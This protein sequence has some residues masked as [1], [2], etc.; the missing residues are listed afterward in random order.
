M[1]LII[2]GLLVLASC[3]QIFSQKVVTTYY[4]PY[5]FLSTK[6]YSE[7]YRVARIDTLNYKFNG[8]VKDYYKNGKLQMIGTYK[9]NVK[10]GEFLFYYPSG[11]LKTRGFYKDNLRW[12]IWTNYYENGKIKEVLVFNDSFLSVLEYYDKNGNPKVLKGTGDWETQYFNDFGMS[13]ETITGSFKDSLRHGTWTYYSKSLLN[14]PDTSFSPPRTEIYENGKFITGK[15]PRNDGTVQNMSFSTIH[16]LPETK[17]FERTERWES[18]IYASRDE[19]PFLKFLPKVD[20]SYF[21]V[22]KL[23]AFPG[24]IDSLTSQI[25]RQ[26]KLKK[27]YIKTQSLLLCMF[28]IIINEK[29][30][31]EIEEDQ[32]KSMLKLY[33]DKTLFY[34]RVLKALKNLPMWSPAVLHQKYVK[35]HFNITISMEKG[36]LRIN[37]SSINQVILDPNLKLISSATLIKYRI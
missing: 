25:S 19:Y 7:Y 36:L 35:S 11:N 1:R 29:G 3:S 37:L 13:N 17:K 14:E 8:I 5:W 30:I 34:Q 32:N 4:N 20:S 15:Y 26:L 2:S 28:K 9:A 12:G 16:V 23:A 24:G 33:P 18:T 27:S 21:P 22:N 6:E 10:Q 31:L